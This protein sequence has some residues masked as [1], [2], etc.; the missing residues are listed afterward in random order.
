MPFDLSRSVLQRPLW[1]HYFQTTDAL[2]FV[3]DSNDRERLPDAKE[4]LWHLLSEEQLQNALL[5]VVANKQDLPNAMPVC[6]IQ[7]GLGLDQVK[8]HSWCKDFRI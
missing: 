5:L 3:V 1:R 8:S 6:E 7:S 4:E 2:V